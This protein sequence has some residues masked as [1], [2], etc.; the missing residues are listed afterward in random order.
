[1]KIGRIA[2][3]AG[4]LGEVK[5]HHFSGEKDRLRGLS[6]LFVGEDE[7]WYDVEALRFQKNTPIFRLTGVMDRNAAEALIGLD[8]KALI[9]EL[10]PEEEDEFFVSDLIGAEILSEDG[11]YVGKLKD[12]ISN[13]AHDL[14]VISG[15]DAKEFLL[16]MI[17]RFV[18]SV[19]A[20]AGRIV[21]FLPAGLIV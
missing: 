11:E 7:R 15:A 20:E 18:L 17:D 16:P 5:L 21:V 1:L 12:I 13:P 6:C 19:D 8:V 4:L 14:L 2:G 10:R 3:A 9:D